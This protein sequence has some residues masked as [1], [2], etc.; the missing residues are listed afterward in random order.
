MQGSCRPVEKEY[1]L[2]SR[3]GPLTSKFALGNRPFIWLVNLEEWITVP[4]VQVLATTSPLLV[5]VYRW[6]DWTSK[7]LF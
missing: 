5:T 4:V 6:M 1:K 7:S 3:H 2:T